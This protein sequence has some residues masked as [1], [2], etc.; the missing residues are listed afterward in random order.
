MILLLISLILLP[1]L[2]YR[3]ARMHMPAYKVT[4]L[5]ISFGLIAAPFSLGLFSTF[6]LHPVGIVTGFPGL[7]L[8]MFHGSPGYHISIQLGLI[9][10]HT[11][12]GSGSNSLLVAVV[13][14][15]IW[16]IIYG[17]LGYAIDKYRHHRQNT[18]KSLVRDAQR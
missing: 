9:P 12:M 10:S 13:N 8:F 15:V 2:T 1:I 6:F 14:G 17:L 18:N 5:G 3:W 11:V 7:V 16:A 4:A